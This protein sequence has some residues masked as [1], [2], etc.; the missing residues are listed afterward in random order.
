MPPITP[1]E[2]DADLFTIEDVEKDLASLTDALLEKEVQHLVREL[3]RRADVY[4]ALQKIVA[5]GSFANE[6]E[7]LAHAV[8]ILQ[9][10]KRV[11]QNA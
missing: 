10:A 7:A 6:V 4:A 9:F 2:S 11:E 8:Q 5:S 3:L 1:H